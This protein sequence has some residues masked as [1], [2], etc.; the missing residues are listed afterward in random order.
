MIPA[1]PIALAPRVGHGGWPSAF[2]ESMVKL[3]IM[4]TF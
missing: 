1:L 4:Q 3:N 2:L